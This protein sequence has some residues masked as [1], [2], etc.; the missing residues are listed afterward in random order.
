MGYRVVVPL[1]MI[2]Q[3]YSFS[4]GYGFS[5]FAM[6]LA[7]FQTFSI[8]ISKSSLSLLSLAVMFYGARLGSFLLLREWTV[9]SKAEQIKSFDKSSRLA[10]IPLAVSVAIFYAFETS[11]LL[12]AARAAIGNTNVVMN[13][14]VGLAWLGAVLEALADGQK[15]AI[16][17]KRNGMEGT[18]EDTFVGPTGGCYRL[19]RH[20]NYFA[21]VLFWFGLLVSGIPSFGKSPIAWGCSI[22][23]FY[24]IFGIMSKATERLDGKQK[25]KYEGQEKYDS[26]VKEVT[27]PI[28]PWSSS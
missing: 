15:F 13:T 19:C 6:G 11:P 26:Y 23:G 22:L 4:V 8:G 10:R 27:A 5:V 17:M 20:P 12:Y 3:G 9:P 24:G 18:S 16:K 14:G 1:T 21:E 28:W 7:L 25:E 2:R